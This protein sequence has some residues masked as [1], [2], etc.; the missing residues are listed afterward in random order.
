MSNAHPHTIPEFI[1]GSPLPKGQG[2]YKRSPVV[3]CKNYLHLHPKLTLALESPGKN[4][5]ISPPRGPLPL[6]LSACATSN[7]LLKASPDIGLD[8]AG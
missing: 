7:L 6:L 2:W 3:R 1:I 4:F 8:Y 5:L